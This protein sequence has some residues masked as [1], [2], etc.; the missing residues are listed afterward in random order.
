MSGADS[1]TTPAASLDV[2]PRQQ[3][4]KRGAGFTVTPPYAQLAP[5][6]HQRPPWWQ[7][8][9]DERRHYCD[10]DAANT[11]LNIGTSSLLPYSLKWSSS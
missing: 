1:E 11:S 9:Y 6:Q 3:T 4:T 8:C 5:H 2:R 7:P 10:A